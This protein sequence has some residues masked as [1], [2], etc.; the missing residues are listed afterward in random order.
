MIALLSLQG[1]AV[2]LPQRS[3]GIC[4]SIPIGNINRA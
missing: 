1:D 2:F 4:G 3:I